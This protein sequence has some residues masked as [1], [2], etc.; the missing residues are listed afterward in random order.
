[1]SEKPLDHSKEAF[2]SDVNETNIKEV[3]L[4]STMKSSFLD[5]SMSVIISRAI[6]E[7]RD[8]FKPVHRRI[9]Y[10]MNDLGMTYSTPHKKSA[11][12][13]GEV[14]GKY[15][16]HGDAA[17]YD[18]MCRLAQP[19]NMRYPLV[20][21]HGN[22][23][24][25]DGDE[26]AASRYT[27]ARL[28]KIA[29]EVVRDINKDTVDFV[30]NY[31]GEDQE[32]V[33]LPCRIPNILINGSTGIAVG[34]TTNIPPH[35]LNEAIDATLA[36]AENPDITVEELMN[37][38][39]GPDFPTGGIILGR[40][41]IRKAY[42][43]GVGSLVVRSKCE[44]EDD[45]NHKDR[46][47]I[48]VKEIPYAINK[49]ILVER[50]GTLAVDKTIEGIADVRDE[51]S[52]EGVK[53]VIE[54][55]KDAIPEVVLNQLYKYSS[56]Q[57]SFSINMLAIF[58]GQPKVFN[59]KQILTHYIDHQVSVVRRKTQFE[60]NKALDR[61]HILEGI[62]IACLNIHDVIK[63]IENSE[64]D[65]LCISTLNDRFGIDEIQAK[66]ILEMKLRRL[67]GI[68][69]EKLEEE[70]KQLNTSI[71][72]YREILANHSKVI[73]VIKQDMEEIKSKYGDERKT[74]ISNEESSIEDEDL[75]PNEQVVITL[76]N[77]GYIKRVPVDTYR[78]QKRGGVGVV[79]MTT[80]S[81]D[82]VDKIIT[83]MTHTDILFF[84]ELGRVFRLRGYQIPEFARQGKGTPVV[85]LL[86]GL[87]KEEKI[88]SIISIDEGNE[89]DS[90][91]F[92]SRQ[93]IIKR[94]SLMEFERINKS[95]K[96]AVTLKE[97]DALLD[98]KKTSGDEEIYIASSNGKAVRFKETEVRVM[99]RTA[100]GVK[101][102]ELPDDAY[103]I[104]VATSSEGNNI[105]VV[106]ENGLG[107]MTPKDDYR[108]TKRG[109]KGV[110]TMN[111]TDKTGKI[112]AIK[113]VQGDEDLLI[114]TTRGT[115]IRTTLEQVKV[116]GRNTQGVKLIR[117][118]GENKVSTIATSEKVEEVEEINESQVEDS[119]ISE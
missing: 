15:H 13:V 57:S 24:N 67:I 26:P 30:P 41:G 87:P 92:V 10:A 82:V 68:E 44:I 104:G 9:V 25:L 42:E 61:I 50:I 45:P 79:G 91:F 115:L 114:T 19:F 54:V 63:I 80:H 35:N 64:T 86:P 7:V 98:V 117:L 66:A 78:Q 46:K 29:Q 89:N 6:P 107:K 22:F 106:S 2:N 17:I 85:N 90:L 43:T 20:D 59:L 58:D 16:P 83:T 28:S 52:M 23:G 81:D 18:A 113:A 8:G 48:I 102:I 39:K 112:A 110:I 56:L 105:L 96:I 37:I 33:I 93:G 109:S 116:A 71:A 53:I 3:D 32:P 34:M 70:I 119:N 118:T 76:T 4:S 62:K 38:I 65:E 69:K 95:G 51:S 40:S 111:I 12:I 49:S 108:L 73:E 21:G 1:M 103:V 72:E 14:M 74:E 36:V 5:Y 75:I 94:T 60:L 31:D 100:S 88:R 77:S 11:R 84:S 101:G 99:G 47:V 97:D 27:E 55:K